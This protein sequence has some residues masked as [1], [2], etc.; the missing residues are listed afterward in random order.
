MNG[1]HPAPA[2]CGVS[3]ANVTTFTLV[4]LVLIGVGA[5]ACYLPARLATHKSIQW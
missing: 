3:P 5:V 4:A 2:L 1:R